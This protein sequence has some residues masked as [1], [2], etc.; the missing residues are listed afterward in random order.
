MEFPSAYFGTSIWVVISRNCI[1]ILVNLGS[2]FVFRRKDNHCLPH[3]KAIHDVV[4]AADDDVGAAADDADEGDGA[5][6]H[7]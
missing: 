1:W 4:D 6:C 2:V 3:L 5:L 7:L